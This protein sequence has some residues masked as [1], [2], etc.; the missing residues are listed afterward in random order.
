MALAI[1]EELGDLVRQANVLNNIGI[2]A[3]FR[4]DWKKSL[5]YYQRSREA[6]SRSGD[7]VGEATAE[8]NIGEIL[9]DQGRLDEAEALF[10]EA[11]RTWRAARYPVGIALAT[12]NLGRL[13][14]RRGN[15]GEAL[16]LLADARTQFADLGAQAFVLEADARVCEALTLS[17]DQERAL[18]A[19]RR[20][21]AAT[22]QA[23][24]AGVSLAMLHRLQGY[25]L[26]QAGCWE[27]AGEA[28]DHSLEQGRRAEAQY[29][30]ALTLEAQAHAAR[31]AGESGDA[32]LLIEAHKIFAALDVITTPRV[33][34]PVRERS[35]VTAMALENTATPASFLHD[36]PR[37]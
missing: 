30:V 3:Y 17:G 13:A 25:A 7:V 24:G 23:Q 27:E 10:S 28:L 9:S 29:E 26:L 36:L 33:P 12:S 4:G 20:T 21:L 19:L 14:S 1:Y 5:V 37:S 15:L 16:T 11:L 22:H 32:P 18:E 2:E 6:R 34:L 8:N 31:L 35:I